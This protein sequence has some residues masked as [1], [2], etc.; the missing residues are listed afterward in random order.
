[1]T[2]L[3]LNISQEL[4]KV[5]FTG[6]YYSTLTTVNPLNSKVKKPVVKKPEVKKPEKASKRKK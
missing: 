6:R 2:T 3:W 1:M 4:S 5:K